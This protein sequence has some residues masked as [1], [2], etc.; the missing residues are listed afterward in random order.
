MAQEVF[1][2]PLRTRR[3]GKPNRE[4]P[5]SEEEV[6]LALRDWAHRHGA[7]P[8]AYEW[9]PAAA[10]ALG[11][12]AE[13][14]ELEYP[15]W[16]SYGTV[17]RL[18]GSWR[19]ALL[20]AGLPSHTPL[21]GTASERARAARSSTLSAVELADLLGV[22]P[23]TVRTY[24]RADVCP[25]CCAELKIK[26][27]AALCQPC[28][29]EQ[30]R[31]RRVISFSREEIVE[32]MRAWA[33]ETGSPPKSWDWSLDNQKWESEYP[34]WPV[35]SLV[36]DRWGG[37]NDAL[38]AAG[39]PAWRRTWDPEEVLQALRDWADARGRSPLSSEWSQASDGLPSLAA[40]GTAFGGW[41]EALA[42]AGL[43]VNKRTW[44]R[45]EVIGALRHFEDIH[46]RRATSQEL[47]VARDHGLPPRSTIR[48]KCGSE[49]AAY[50][51]LDWPTVTP[52]VSDA[53]ILAALQAF[54]AVHDG[55]G[56]M[57]RQWNDAGASPSSSLIIRRFGT[58]N[59]A[60]E[61]AGVPRPLQPTVDQILDAIRAFAAEHGRPPLAREWTGP[62][63]AQLV[64]N[65]CGSWAQ[66]LEA[67]GFPRPAPR[68]KPVSTRTR[69]TAET[70]LQA[71]RSFE[72][73][74]GRRPSEE[75]ARPQQHGIPSRSV[76]VRIFGSVE[77]V[78]G[79]L[80]WPMRPAAIYG[81][82]VV[83]ALRAFGAEHGR[84]PTIGE[85]RLQRMK[86]DAS[87]AIRRFGSWSAALK[88]AGFASGR[89]RR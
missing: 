55:E 67:A 21:E 57:V 34:R 25:Q 84:P 68:P 11:R 89:G 83:E 17:K 14:W 39:L 36:Y 26:A 62:G 73:A 31:D 71:L 33:L 77:E 88:A 35:R 16:P 80:G 81:E 15:R 41:S 27:E 8:R 13:R 22:S 10:A 53:E 1:D 30:P 85:W 47:A 49:R 64:A 70:A 3:R 54:A 43:E 9:E 48:R 2:T 28:R 37:W 56:P 75:F 45:S 51:A 23:W 7:P 32:A 61:V 78:Y 44:T 69:W 82:E 50:D 72:Q 12:T 42:A 65:R 60:L 87:T 66:A 18:C 59:R 74:N 40:V 63:S 76:L 5:W 38:G 46:G 52:Q 24:R 6:L 4:R 79:R 86:P 19:G 29:L 20:A 58:W